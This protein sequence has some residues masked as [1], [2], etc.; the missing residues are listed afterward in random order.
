MRTGKPCSRGSA[1]PF[2]PTA[3]SAPRSGSS[4]TAV[5]VPAVQPSTLVDRSWSA[6]SRTPASRRRSRRSTPTKRAVETRRAADLV[7]H[8]G[9]RQGPLDER[10]GEEVGERERELAVDHAVDPQ[11]PVR[12]RERG[13]AQRGVDPVEVRVGRDHR[14]RAE[15]GEVRAGRYRRSGGDPGG[16]EQ[17]G[18]LGAGV[19]DAAARAAGPLRPRRPR[20]RRRAPSAAEPCRTPRRVD[21]ARAGVGGST[22]RTARRGGTRE[23]P[24]GAASGPPI[25]PATSR[26]ARG[27]RSSWA[28][29]GA[30]QA[31]A[32]ATT[33][34]GDDDRDR[35]AS[36]RRRAASPASA[37]TA[38]QHDADPGEQHRLVRGA[39]R[40]G[41][42]LDQR[43][44]GEPD[45]GGGDGERRR[46]GGGDERGGEVPG[47]DGGGH[48]RDAQRRRG[49]RGIRS[50]GDVAKVALGSLDAP[51]A[52]FGASGG[53]GS[54]G[55]VRP[56]RRA[57]PGGSGHGGSAGR[58]ERAPCGTAAPRP[59]RSR[60][61]GRRCRSPGTRSPYS[62]RRSGSASTST[63][64]QVS[65]SSP[66]MRATSSS[67][68][69]HAGQPTRV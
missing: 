13:D 64:R 49:P 22:G 59:S 37:A 46:G 1:S 52:A 53:A 6:P 16:G 19:A 39:E 28:N 26:P 24:P 32:P 14:G 58:A 56:G 43:Q 5:G 41:R 45:H 68:F 23:Q 51:K 57:R 12:G 63:A 42:E 11:G 34:E 50:R 3:S 18:H 4:T 61:R 8:A 65:P 7:G 15:R 27:R 47:A 10:A 2:I 44:R 31:A 20:R 9:Q 33:P 48:R 67:A 36:G 21:R 69:A 35:R 40:R 60:A 25:T 29:D 30:V 54:A 17:P 55:A 66:Q 62:A 38:D